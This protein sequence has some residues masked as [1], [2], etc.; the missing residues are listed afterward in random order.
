MFHCKNFIIHKKK[1]HW[2]EVADVKKLLFEK[3][4]SFEKI[5]TRGK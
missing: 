2:E 1:N 5:A 3:S 4:K